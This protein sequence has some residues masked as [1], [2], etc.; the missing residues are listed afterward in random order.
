MIKMC[1]NKTY[2][3]VRTGKYMSDSFPIQNCLKQGDDLSPLLFNFVLEYT[4]MKVA[5]NQVGL[6]LNG[7][8]QHLAYA[9]SVNLLEDNMVTVNKN[10]ETLNSARKKVDLEVNVEKLSKYWCLVNRMQTNIEI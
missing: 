10:T 7:I 1:L 5:E 6:I 4:I 3:N 2:I 8:H 9:D